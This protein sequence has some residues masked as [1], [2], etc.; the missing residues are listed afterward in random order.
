MWSHTACL[1]FPALRLHRKVLSICNSQNKFIHMQNNGQ[2]ELSACILCRGILSQHFRLASAVYTMGVGEGHKCDAPAMATSDSAV[3]MVKR[4]S[5]F[6]RRLTSVSSRPVLEGG[7]LALSALRV[8]AAPEGSAR[9]QAPPPPPLPRPSCP[10]RWRSVAN[11][12]QN[13]T[14]YS[15]TTTILM[16]LLPLHTLNNK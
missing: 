2:G 13:F 4:N 12:A 8:S 3:R 1:H 11:N 9:R 6:D 7:L 15:C 5:S 14:Y 16:L 10:A